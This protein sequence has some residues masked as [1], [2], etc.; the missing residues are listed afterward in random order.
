MKVSKLKNMKDTQ[1]DVDINIY[2]EGF[3]HLLTDL[4][5][6]SLWL[7]TN[8]DTVRAKIRD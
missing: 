1:T 3:E 2:H 4:N 5:M 7:A 8:I 6:F